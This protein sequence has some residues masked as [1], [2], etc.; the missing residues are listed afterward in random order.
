MKS[1]LVRVTTISKTPIYISICA[2]DDQKIFA[3]MNITAFTVGTVFE[4]AEKALKECVEVINKVV[5]Y[6]NDGD[7]VEALYSPP[8]GAFLTNEEMAN[9]LH[10]MTD[11]KADA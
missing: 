7:K 11:N 3:L 1:Q 9:V 8:G 6:R 4:S 2:D 10:Q 5:N